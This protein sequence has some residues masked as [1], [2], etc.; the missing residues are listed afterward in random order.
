MKISSSVTRLLVLAAVVC[1]VSLIQI[2]QVHAQVYAVPSGSAGSAGT[3]NTAVG[4]LAGKQGTNN[5]SIG[6][7]AGDNVAGN[8]NTLIGKDAGKAVST[9]NG[10]TTLGTNAGLVVSTGSNNTF[11][12][13]GAGSASTGSSNVF[14]GKDAGANETGSN[15]LYI[16]NSN[17]STPLILGDFSSNQVAINTAITGNYTFNVGGSLNTTSLYINGAAYSPSKWTLAGN[18]ILYNGQVLVGSYGG[19]VPTGYQFAVGGKII[20]EEVRVKVKNSWPDYVF[21]SDY[22]LSTLEELV[23]YVSANK[24]LPEVPASSEVAAEGIAVGEMNAIL[25]KK[26]EEMTLHMIQLNERIKTLEANQKK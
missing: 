4:Y 1:Y 23:Q 5:T 14:I 16:D 17:L 12:G 21:E 22:K 10:N 11:L 15:K 13:F 18:Y 6:K 3:D 25:L 9:G 8:N 7:S 26:L 20:C 24:H 19:G 2:S